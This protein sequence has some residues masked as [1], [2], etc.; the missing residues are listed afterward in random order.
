MT[1]QTKTQPKWY[2]ESILLKLAIITIIVL[3][4]L[5]PSAWIQGL[6]TDREGYQQQT[7]SGVADKWS[8]TQL[9]QGP[10]LVLP[11]K[12]ASTAGV[13]KNLYILPQNLQIKAAIKTELFES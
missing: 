4:L 2:Q 11:Y 12:K 9:I 8:G 6:V 3:V 1:E 10:V 13:V 7:M 5:I